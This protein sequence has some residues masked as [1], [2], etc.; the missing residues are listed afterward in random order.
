MAPG[1]VPDDVLTALADYCA[2][3][4]SEVAR[5]QSQLFVLLDALAAR[6]VAAVPFKGPML[7]HELAA[8]IGKRSPGDLDL[9]VGAQDVA[10]VRDVLEAHGYCD[11]GQG[12]RAGVMTEAQRRIYERHQCEY[13]YTRDSDQTVVE[14]H[15]GLSQRPLAIDVDYCGMLDRARS[16][17]VAGRH[18]LSLTPEDLLVALAVHGSKHQWQRL[19]WIRDLAG[20]LMVYPN[21]ALDQVLEAATARGCRR[22]LLLS[23]AVAQEFGGVAV[24]T[25]IAAVLASDKNLVSLQ[26]DIRAQVFDSQAPEPRNDRIELF[27]FKLRERASDRT[28]Y[29][30]RTIF[31]P[32]REH[33]ETV[34][35]P[36]GLSWGYWVLKLG[37][38][39]AFAPAWRTYH[40]IA[41][42]YWTKALKT[43]LSQ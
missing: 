4:D 12:V 39:Y 15:W 33:L 11:A 17:P 6:G 23:L 22:L 9:L 26:D 41:D 27:R 38:D 18:V 16:V 13:Q 2:H 20:V 32:R 34:R 8:A 42:K 36:A 24:R 14:P 5:L 30:V 40:R 31:S 35:L 43:I 28:K 37:I 29:V 1:L 7:G 10:T 21:L 19:S 3:L 25:D